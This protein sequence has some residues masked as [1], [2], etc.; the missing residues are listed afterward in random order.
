ML[1]K[2][3]FKMMLVWDYP[4]RKFERWVVHV[5][6]DG[7]CLA[8]GGECSVDNFL[9]GFASQQLTWWNNCAPIEEEKPVE[10]TRYMTRDE[11]MDFVVS[12]PDIRVR[13]DGADW[14]LPYSFGYVE[15]ED[16]KWCYRRNGEYGPAHK[17]RVLE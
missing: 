14:N 8:I 4:S 17:F 9:N 16:M 6:Q 12:D 13:F 1:K 15:I 7:S 3:D 10:D 11:A 5:F 2:K